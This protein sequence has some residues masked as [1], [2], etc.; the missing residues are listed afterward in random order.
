MDNNDDDYD[1][2]DVS[3]D[4][5]EEEYEAA[6]NIAVEKSERAQ[7]RKKWEAIRKAQIDRAADHEGF[8][9]ELENS[10]NVDG[11]ATIAAYFGKAVI[12]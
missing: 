9:A 4:H 2:D 11:F 8:F 6:A 3:I 7:E 10:E 12:M 5:E 1:I